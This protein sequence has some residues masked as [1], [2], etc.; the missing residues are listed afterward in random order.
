MN[1][2]FS[3]HQQQLQQLQQQKQQS[4]GDDSSLTLAGMETV[5]GDMRDRQAKMV[6]AIQDAHH[7]Q[8]EILRAAIADERKESAQAQLIFEQTL[9]TRYENMVESLHSKI[10]A[11]SE[12]RIQRSLDSLETAARAESDRSRASCETLQRAESQLAGKFKAV[13]ADLRKSWEDEE[14]GRSL[15]LEERLRSHYSVVL[16]HMEAQLKMALKLQDD[17]DKLWLEDVENRNRHQVETLRAFEDK[18][19][20]LYDTR[21]HEYAEKTA[22]QLA[23]YEQELLEA[24]SAAASERMQ[25]E[26]RMRRLKLSC[27]RWKTAFQREMHAKYQDLSAAMEERYMSEVA[28]L[29]QEI[30]DSKAALAEANGVIDAKEKEMAKMQEMAAAPGGAEGDPP[31][32]CRSI[33]ESLFAQWTELKTP[34]AERVEALAALLDASLPSPQLLARFEFLQSKLADRVPIA[35]AISRRQFL[36]Y[37]LKLASRMDGSS[38]S[39]SGLSAADRA[40]FI[41]ELTE[42]QSSLDASTKHYE[43]KYG[44]SYFKTTSLEPVAGSSSA[45]STPSQPRMASQP[46]PSLD[47]LSLPAAASQQQG[48]VKG[49]SSPPASYGNRPTPRK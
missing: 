20:R 8:A 1:E 34:A 14:T 29:L 23:R 13:V 49:L 15:Q 27:S 30:G 18:C 11:E 10:Q 4:K 2:S 41:T 48:G 37:K 17:A 43:K 31:S 44:E 33:R 36:E 12:A 32:S 45:V 25:F 38:T 47:H 26:S 24:G 7:R 21:L 19:R 35:Q 6:Q 28:G 16:E 40:A 46:P 3:Q 22:Q 9:K 39:S 5:V 42:I